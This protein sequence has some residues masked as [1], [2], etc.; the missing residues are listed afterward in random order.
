MVE[1][2]PPIPK[3]NQIKHTY[4]FKTTLTKNKKPS[5]CITFPI[6]YINILI[7]NFRNLIK[8]PKLIFTY[9]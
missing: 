3:F 1:P 7:S 8:V 4:S 9:N 6:N 5:N 2:N